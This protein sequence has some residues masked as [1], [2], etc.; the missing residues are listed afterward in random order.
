MPDT[1]KEAGR[2]FGRSKRALEYIKRRGGLIPQYERE[3]GGMNFHTPYIT[4]FTVNTPN[5]KIALSISFYPREPRKFNAAFAYWTSGM[6]RQA[7]PTLPLPT[8]PGNLLLAFVSTGNNATG[9]PISLPTPIIFAYPNVVNSG[10]AASAEWEAHAISPAYAGDLASWHIFCI[11]SRFVR[12]DERTTEP[13][14]FGAGGVQN[15]GI[16]VWLVEVPKVGK[17]NGVTLH[18]SDSAGKTHAGIPIVIGD[19]LGGFLM[20]GVS[21]GTPDFGGRLDFYPG[22]GIE[23]VQDNMVTNQYAPSSPV[24]GAYRA[25]WIGQY[26]NPHPDDTKAL[27]VTWNDPY[28]HYGDDIQSAGATVRLPN[29]R[30]ANIPRIPYPQNNLTIVASGGQIV[31]EL[32][33][34]GVRV[35]VDSQ[36][37]SQYIFGGPSGVVDIEHN[38]WDDIDLRMWVKSAGQHTLVVTC[39][40]G[41]VDVDTKFEV[42]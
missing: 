17:P 9:A 35:F 21:V 2:D 11:Y 27:S 13:N 5:R 20:G 1:L 30:K 29:L 26:S 34:S 42:Y 25:I 32:Y 6:I 18:S 37:I 39:E 14:V 10:A 4:N 7:I 15:V 22:S 38:R 41:S 12:Q 19:P 28:R 23:T 8:T 24:G 33:A 36:D 31:P 16:G 40:I 3:R